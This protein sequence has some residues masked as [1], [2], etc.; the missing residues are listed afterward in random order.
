MF[1]NM[2]LAYETLSDGMKKL[3]DGLVGVNSS[4][5]NYRGG[6]AKKMK[7]LDGMK[8][9]YI[10]ASEISVAEHPVVRTHPETRRKSLYVSR[11]HTSH[12]KGMSEEESGPLIDFLSDHAV[13]PEFTCRMSWE[14]GTLV[15]WDNRCT[16]HFAVNDYNGH[17]R[18][19]H[20]VTLIGDRPA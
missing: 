8:E 7:E 13:R 16:Q 17:R 20:R 1:A 2:N 19:M 6:R 11:A 5:Q 3:L 18:R 14:P 9:K 12:F 15:F 4:A 10:E